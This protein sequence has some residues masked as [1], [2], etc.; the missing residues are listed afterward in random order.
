MTH[1]ETELHAACS[2]GYT[3]KAECWF[4]F[5][6]I[7]QKVAPLD[8]NL[9]ARRNYFPAVFSLLINSHKPLYQR[10]QK[11]VSV[12]SGSVNLTV[13]QAREIVLEIA[14]SKGWVEQRIREKTDPDTQRLLKT[15]ESI[16]EELGDAVETYVLLCGNHRLKK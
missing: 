10:L 2:F 3:I 1:G 5:R 13:L 15:I 4:W 7:E 8:F 9:S 6:L 14:Q 12:M 16:Q 11:S